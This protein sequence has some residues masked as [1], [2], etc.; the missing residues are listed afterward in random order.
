MLE[1]SIKAELIQ[2]GKA[3]AIANKTTVN[4]DATAGRDEVLPNPAELLL[5]SLSACIL[6]NIE[7]YSDILKIPY[8]TAKITV[9]GWRKDVPP[10]FEKVEYSIEI[11][12]DEEIKK[13]NLLH[14]NILK[15]GT[16]TNTVSAA[17]ELSG[18]MIKM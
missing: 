10:S 1:Y 16:I 12:T 3:K 18:E 7:R 4:F 8:R 17:C 14:K 5:T 15:F 6:K 13:V 11:D 9:K 2:G